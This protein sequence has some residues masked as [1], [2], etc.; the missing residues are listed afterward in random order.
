V[1]SGQV[2]FCM[3]ALEQLKSAGFSPRGMCLLP[4]SVNKDSMLL[5]S[6]VSITLGLPRSVSS[7][8]SGS[9]FKDLRFYAVP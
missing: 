8:A 6:T 4:K 2:M 5:C 9:L 3:A 7:T 1:F